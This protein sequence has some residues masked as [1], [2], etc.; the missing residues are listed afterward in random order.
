M[1]TLVSWVIIAALSVMLIQIF[2]SGNIW[3]EDMVR[4]A[5]MAT[6]SIM[7]CVLALFL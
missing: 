7:G 1:I 6:G 4:W 5:V 3:R 2:N